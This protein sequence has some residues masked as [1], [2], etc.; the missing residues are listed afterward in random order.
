MSTQLDVRARLPLVD[1]TLPALRALSPPQYQEFMQCFDELV[2]ADQRH[3]P[4]RVD[5]ASD[6]AAT[7][8]AAV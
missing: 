8:A 6:S 3:R 4:V 1:M 2:Q 5:A 7:P